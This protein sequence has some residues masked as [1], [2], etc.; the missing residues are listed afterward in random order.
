MTDY[1]EGDIVKTRLPCR[2]PTLKKPLPRFV[3]DFMTCWHPTLNRT[4]SSLVL[5]LSREGRLGKW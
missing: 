3:L 4:K 5:P 1:C 2:T